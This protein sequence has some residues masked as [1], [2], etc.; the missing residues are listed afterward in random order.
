MG[1]TLTGTTPQDTYDSLIKVTDNG[2]L[3]GTAK[4]LSDGLGNDSAL[5]LST[6]AVAIG[7]T[8]A[9]GKLNI[10]GSA[11]SGLN[12]THS[13]NTVVAELVEFSGAQGAGLTLKN[14]AGTTN[15]LL[16]AGGESYINGGNVGIGTAS[17]LSLLNLAK[18]TNSGSGATFP[19][20]IVANTLATQGDGSSTFNF[21][22]VNVSSGDGAVNMF[23]GTTYAA[24]T[25]APSGFLN[26][27]S[28]HPLIVKTNNTEVARFLAGGGL[29]FNGDTAAANA[30]DDYEEGTWT[31][32]SN[33]AGY[34]TSSAE[35]SY[36]KIG[37]QVTIRGRVNFSA[38]D[39]S[40]TSVFIFTGLPFTPSSEFQGVCRENS[41]TGAMFLAQV[42]QNPDGVL[43]S[44]DGVTTGSNVPF[45]TSKNYIFTI[46]YFV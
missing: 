28:N 17:P 35:G 36:T 8:T 41:T 32:A 24:G 1:T 14:A 5:A 7:T 18:S 9:A 42:R 44:M 29:T 34:T 37:R 25:W 11:G 40:S 46:T 10:K 27:V 2:P 6:S 13:N 22:D 21:A 43:N 19:R 23:V 4:Y 33:S 38:V 26:V 45:A 12:I 3:S 15:V 31:P 20:L 39:A 30:L 16:N